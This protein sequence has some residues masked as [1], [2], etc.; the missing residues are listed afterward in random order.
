[1]KTAIIGKNNII[2]IEKNESDLGG[3]EI[4]VSFQNR[5]GTKPKISK[6]IEAFKPL[7]I[8]KNPTIYGEKTIQNIEKRIRAREEKKR[9]IIEAREIG[10]RI[11]NKETEKLFS[12]KN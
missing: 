12:S 2:L 4:N 6:D 9:R 10:K 11:E 7:E 1:M 3:I 5:T 8:G